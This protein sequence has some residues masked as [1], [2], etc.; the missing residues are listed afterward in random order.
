MKNYICDAFATIH[1]T[2]VVSAER[3]DEVAQKALTLALLEAQEPGNDVLSK[4]SICVREEDGE[5]D[6]LD[7]DD[8]FD[9]ALCD[10]DGLVDEDFLT[11]VLQTA[12]T[13]ARKR[14]DLSPEEIADGVLKAASDS[15]DD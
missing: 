11:E 10:D 4:V 9:D 14:R 13:I 3:I 1:S 15:L 6:L 8:L 5:Y 2:V 7:M 12:V